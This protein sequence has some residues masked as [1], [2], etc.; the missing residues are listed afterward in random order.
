MSVYVDGLVGY[1]EAHIKPEARQHGRRWCH[2][3]A[4]TEDELHAFAARLGLRPSWYQGNYAR[5]ALRHYDLV[6]SK[7]ALAVRLGAVEVDA[8]AHLSAR[9]I[10]EMREG[11]A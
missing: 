1:D 7:R 4:D 3:T 8:R 9:V 11:R 5:P 2:L 10:A 6:P